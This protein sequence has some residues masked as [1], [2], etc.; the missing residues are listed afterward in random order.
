MSGAL[1]FLVKKH[2]TSLSPLVQI[3]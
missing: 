1:S 3:T 2:C